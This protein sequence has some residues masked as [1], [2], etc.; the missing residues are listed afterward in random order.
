MLAY[1][2]AGS[3]VGNLV[4]DPVTFGLHAEDAESTRSCIFVF[5]ASSIA[6]GCFADAGIIGHLASSL[7]QPAS[8]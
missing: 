8:A 5:G 1:E 6:F 4:V 2:T 3:R 7:T